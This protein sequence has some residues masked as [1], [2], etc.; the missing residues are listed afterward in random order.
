PFFF[1]AEDGIRDFHVTGVQTCALPIFK[2]LVENPELMLDPNQPQAEIS[3]S[4]GGRRYALNFV[5]VGKEGAKKQL[6]ADVKEAEGKI[7]RSEERRVG[8][9][10]RTRG[11]PSNEKPTDGT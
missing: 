6:Y 5:P 3:K 10:W 8:K 2:A 11:R 9:E 4:A 7:Q 1:H